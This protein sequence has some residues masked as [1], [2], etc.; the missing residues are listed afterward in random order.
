MS[1]INK[2]I[3]ERK[4]K[5]EEL[6]K[7][8]VDVYPRNFSTT[9]V[10]SQ[11]REKYATLKAEEK[12]EETVSLA[13]RIMSLRRMGKAS[14]AHIKDGTGKLQIY[15]REDIL[16]EKN[17]QIFRKLDIGDFIGVTGKIFS[18]KTG[19]LSIQVEDLILLAKSLRPLPEKWH[20][21]KDIET[22]YR[23]RY[24]DLLVNEQVQ[25]VF[26]TR[27]LIIKAIRGFLDNL[28]FLEVETPMMQSVVGGAIAKPFLTHH[29]ALDMELYLRISPELF[30]K[31]LVVGGL[32]KVYEVNRNFRNEGV[33]TRHNPEFT[34]LEVYQ[35]YSDYNVM[36]GL[37]ERMILFIAKEVLGREDL[38]YQKSKISLG[39]IPWKRF[40]LYDLLKEHAGL[41]FTN[42][43]GL[44]EMRK[45]A[46]RLN[47]KY[48]KDSPKSKILDHIFEAY[49][50]KKLIQ[51]TFVLDYPTEF[52][53]LAKAKKDNPELVERFELF[54]G[55]EELAN[56]YSELNDPVEQRRR[57]EEQ[58]KERDI[59][60]GREIQVDEDYLRALEYGMPPCGGLGLGVDRLVMV[61][62]NCNS[63]RDV[64]LF[65]Q[66]RKETE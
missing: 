44:S 23:Q 66:M 8:G 64:I 41:D 4:Q 55:G 39:R 22:R 63:I 7:M 10:I 35:A 65:P 56:A 13:G 50:Q 11:V 30:L 48:E 51:P 40:S 19:E 5:L 24:I 12:T 14:F 27:S 59:G 43:H 18:T 1:E 17:Y 54:I 9:H 47:V 45:A 36:M 26:S 53:P 34:M 28:G 62:T 33:S 6:R 57:M 46:D 61:F 32:E 15:I 25:N 29:Q 60:E 3:S 21:L 49:V 37:C 42:I 58:V 2:L 20:G 31:R 38:I 16:G 52:S